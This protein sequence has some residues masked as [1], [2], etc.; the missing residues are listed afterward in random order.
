MQVPGA[1]AKRSAERDDGGA[2]I[3]SRE[4][5]DQRRSG[6]GAGLTA[7]GDR[8]V[9]VRPGI[10][11]T[12]AAGRSCAAAGSAA[13]GRTPVSTGVR[14][15]VAA[16]VPAGARAAVAARAAASARA[17]VAASVPAGARAAVAAR[18]SAGARA[19]AGSR[20]AAGARRA[21]A[22]CRPLAAGSRQE[23]HGQESPRPSLPSHHQ[24]I[25]HGREKV[26]GRGHRRA[27]AAR[28][29]RLLVAIARGCRPSTPYRNTCLTK[30]SVTGWCCTNMR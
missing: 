20:A 11:E 29:P 3:L 5:H 22:S 28:R 17:A 14:A 15:A 4:L 26:R 27:D 18:V 16:R 7:A 2:A 24:S 12:R 9:G 13:T 23:C 1:E 30:V 10:G 8:G 6:R 21:V 25:S 19:A